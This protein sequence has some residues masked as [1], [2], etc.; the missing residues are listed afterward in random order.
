VEAA[1]RKSFFFEAT[2]TFL[3]SFL[4]FFFPSVLRRVVNI[5]FRRSGLDPRDFVLPEE[6]E[7]TRSAG[8]AV[9]AS[10]GPASS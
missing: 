2:F 7:F 9:D 8:V 6:F 1:G 5:G 3:P 10:A 4:P